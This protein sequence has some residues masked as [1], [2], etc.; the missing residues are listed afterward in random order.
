MYF[1]RVEEAILSIFRPACS[2]K[3]KL[4]FI[5]QNINLKNTLLEQYS[6]KTELYFVL[7]TIIK[8]DLAMLRYLTAI[9]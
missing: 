8:A 4:Y 3:R 9:A 2:E 1:L 6:S 7:L 5:I